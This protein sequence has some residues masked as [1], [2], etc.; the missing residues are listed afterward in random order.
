MKRVRSDVLTD[1]V[2]PLANSV[3]FCE[4]LTV[5]MEWADPVTALMLRMTCTSLYA[6]LP[7]QKQLGYGTLYPHRGNT[8]PHAYCMLVTCAANWGHLPIVMWIYDEP[9]FTVKPAGSTLCRAAAATGQQH[10]I[11]WAR[12]RDPPLAWDKLTSGY[13]AQYGTL[14]HF[15]W[16][17]A[18]DPPCPWGSLTTF[19]ASAGGNLDILQWALTQNPP[20]R[21][22]TSMADEAIKHNHVHIL[23][24][25][26]YHYT[27]PFYVTLIY[28]IVEAELRRRPIVGIVT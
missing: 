24:W 11:E 12:A 20:C 14:E 5:I 8:L 25:L 15:Q 26:Y 3:L 2:N 10:I 27:P 17:R 22:N 1:R 19:M 6:H 28:E 13:V 9:S 4:N 18:Q 7:T 16:I 21:I 23:L